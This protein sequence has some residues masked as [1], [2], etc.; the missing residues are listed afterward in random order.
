ML[1]YQWIFVIFLTVNQSL[2]WHPCW[3][4]TTLSMLDPPAC[5]SCRSRCGRVTDLQNQP[6]CSCDDQCFI[7][8]DCCY[9]MSSECPDEYA[10]SRHTTEV[11][12][13]T[14]R[15]VT[16]NSDPEWKF[17]YMVVSYC[18]SDPQAC[19]WSSK[20]PY[21]FI[22]VVD[23]QTGIHYVNVKCAVC[24]GAESLVPWRSNITCRERFISVNGNRSTNFKKIETM[25]L[26]REAVR[27]PL[28]TAQCRLDLYPPAEIKQPRRCLPFSKFE[29]N[30]VKPCEN[31]D[32]THACE[33]L[34]TNYFHIGK[35]IYRNH[36]CA[37]CTKRYRS[38]RCGVGDGLI[39]ETSEPWSTRFEMSL[40]FDFDPNDG[41]QVGE[42]QVSALKCP[43]G[44]K[45]L[46]FRCRRMAH[47]QLNPPMVDG[48]TLCNTEVDNLLMEFVADAIHNE[49]NVNVNVKLSFSSP[50]VLFLVFSNKTLNSL[51]ISELEKTTR[52]YVTHKVLSVCGSDERFNVSSVKIQVLQLRN[53]C[54][55]LAHDTSEFEI[56]TNE[57]LL[58]K[59]TDTIFDKSG[60]YIYNGTTFIC[61]KQ[62]HPERSI[63][64]G[65]LTIILLVIS[66]LALTIRI[67][68]HFLLAE[69]QNDAGRVQT[70]LASAM[71]L[72]YLTLLIGPTLN[73]GSTGCHILAVF[74]H[75]ALLAMFSWM[76]VVSVDIWRML[77]LS[78][79]LF[80]MQEKGI[81]FI[82]FSIFAW[83]SPALF[84][85]I[86]EILNF[87]PVDT[88][89]QPQ[90]GTS[91]C[92]FNQ[93]YDI[94]DVLY[95]N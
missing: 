4:N 22:P 58:M 44:E 9:D 75:W 53:D 66:V 51:D 46:N 91:I 40:I 34:S 78:S 83:V 45:W 68:T 18:K 92:W 37:L 47:D 6:S 85:V 38:L 31:D 81:T 89:F 2:A 64:L 11:H 67:I 32:L 20:S 93:R 87:L 56:L 48:A 88:R 35:K 65:I 71:W 13:A 23:R 84:V 10:F 70:S 43:T 24:N 52:Q 54:S 82:Y 62:K 17:M 73:R 95:V 76:S 29:F 86:G 27:N 41:L 28:K 57:T 79:K 16:V 63:A 19:T 25:T 80:K 30:C 94:K 42:S 49:T 72:A 60:W 55:F 14:C 90:Y 50:S 74:R 36:Y 5:A 69:L 33:H 7:Y 77:W 26:I 15:S 39:R 8:G 3:K 59:D 61:T 12:N 1:N 21:D